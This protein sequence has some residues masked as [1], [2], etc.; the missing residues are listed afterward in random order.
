MKRLF[1]AWLLIAIIVSGLAG[2]LYATVQQVL[3]SDANDPQIQTAEDAATTLGNG[4]SLQSVAPTGKVDISASLAPYII[5]FDAGGKPVA[6]SAQLN[7]QTP[8]IPSGIFDAVRQKG[9]DRITWQPQPGIRSAIVVVQFRGSGGGF[10]L[11]GRSLR[12][13]EMREDNFLHLDLLGWA[14]IL[15][16]SFLASMFLFGRPLPQEISER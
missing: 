15:V 10:V 11:A 6:S 7:G 16:V 4:G 2:L 3:R 14:A 13:V 12:E 5:V 9:E 1:Q 8:T